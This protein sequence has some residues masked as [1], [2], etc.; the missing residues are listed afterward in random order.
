MN[1]NFVVK[2]KQYGKIYKEHVQ[3]NAKAAEWSVLIPG[4]KYVL[5]VNRMIIYSLFK[6]SV[7][8]MSVG[9]TND[10]F[11]YIWLIKDEDYFIY[12]FIYFLSFF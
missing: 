6:K 2:K 9:I 10:I 1:V 3:V 8:A 5:F 4:M 11:I 12:K 7:N